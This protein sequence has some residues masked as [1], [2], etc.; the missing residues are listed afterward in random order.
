[1][2]S[3]QITSSESRVPAWVEKPW[4]Q[5]AAAGLLTLVPVRKYPGWLREAIMWVPAVGVTTVLVTPRIWEA[6][7]EAGRNAAE[8]QATEQGP[9]VEE[10]EAAEQ[11]AAEQ[12]QMNDPDSARED[13]TTPDEP[14]DL[15]PLPTA[16]RVAA[17][18]GIGLAMGA[19]MY[20]YMRLAL[21]A[22][23][24]L[25]DKLRDMGVSRPRIV[26]AVLGGAASGGI[27]WVQER[28]AHTTGHHRSPAPDSPA[29]S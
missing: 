23:S 11:E 27:A 16:P 18:W 26:L 29:S 17:R 8:E 19:A 28:H 4:V 24:A 1:M 15:K 6:M 7:A 3:A 21:W 2:T 5:G 14:E 9:G 10:Q 20:G 25:E 12:E 13:I 22:D